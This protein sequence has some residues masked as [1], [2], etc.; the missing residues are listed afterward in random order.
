M[1]LTAHPVS[2]S[3]ALYEIRSADPGSRLRQWLEPG[4]GWVELG[5]DW[6][7]LAA[8]LREQPPIFCRH[9]CPVQAHVPLKQD[10]ADL[11]DLA[12]ASR[13]FLPDLDPAQTFSVQTRLISSGWPYARYDVNERLAKELTV[14]GV[15]LDVRRPEQILS[16]VL[17]PEQGYL[18]LSRAADNLS[19]WAGGA[20]RFM[21]E[22]EQVS[23]AEFK[24]L[25]AAELFE[26]SFP[27]RGVALDLGASPGGWTRV[28]RNHGLD[29]IAVDPGDLDRRIASDPAVRHVRQTAQAYLPKT[30]QQFDVI[31]NDMRMDAQVSAR[32]MVS[33]ARNLE[34]GGWAL[35]TLKLPK[36]GIER[37]AASALDV[38]RRRYTVIGARQLFHNR[39]E[40]TVALRPAS[41]ASPSLSSQ[42]RR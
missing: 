41:V 28:L 15:P 7:S 14:G 6:D 32:I 23:R 1:I 20:R 30:D 16:V 22:E 27:A 24:L 38:L 17:A 25:E 9:I 4:V 21:Q 18:G 26:L 12:E 33:A 40:I 35:L 37:V 36:K 31:L 13:Q 39:S 42:P 29:V 19:N 34:A 5:T 8:R 10:V 3:A 11:D 2:G